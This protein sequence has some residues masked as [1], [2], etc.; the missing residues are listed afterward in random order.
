MNKFFWIDVETTGLDPQQG[1]VLEVSF[2]VTDTELN[3]IDIANWIIRQHGAEDYVALRAS[4]GDT[5]A[6]TV[7]QMHRKTGLWEDILSPKAWSENDAAKAMIQ[8]LEQNGITLKDPMCGSS[9]HFDRAWMAQHFPDVHALFH[10]RNIDISTLKELC[11]RLQ[12]EMFAYQEN[13]LRPSMKE[14][15]HRA[16]NDVENTIAEA[17]WYFDNFLFI[18]TIEVISDP[19]EI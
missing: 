17:R 6:E 11:R 4:G 9:V 16:E 2:A 13:D 18:P 8:F 12:P 19:G 1:D 10:Y 5:G 14:P 7:L 3:I 15:F